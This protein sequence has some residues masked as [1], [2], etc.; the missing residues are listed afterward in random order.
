MCT[1][2]RQRT[3]LLLPI[4]GLALFSCSRDRDREPDV[5]GIEVI[6]LLALP[7]VDGGTY[8]PSSLKGKRLLVNF[9]TPG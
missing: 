6:P 2:M 5:R 8:D 7:T 4:L 9:W 3:V 1:L